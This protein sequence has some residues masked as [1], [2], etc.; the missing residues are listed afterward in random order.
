MIVTGVGEGRNRGVSQVQSDVT[1]CHAADGD[2]ACGA[3][4]HT[5]DRTA[6]SPAYKKDAFKAG[7]GP[8]V[9]KF[10]KYAIVRGKR[11]SIVTAATVMACEPQSRVVTDLFGQFK[12]NEC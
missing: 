8:S 3:D 7:K 6:F 12:I 9:F 11:R 5:A 10:E 4:S 2:L 1:A